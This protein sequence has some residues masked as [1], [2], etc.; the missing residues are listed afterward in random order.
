MIL[1]LLGNI[2]LTSIQVIN[3]EYDFLVCSGYCP[4]VT[5]EP[6]AS[7]FNSSSA[8]KVDIVP[9]TGHGL[10]F[11]TNA[12]ETYGTIIDFLKEHGI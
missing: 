8:F 1:N 7:N 10:N 5:D 9:K 6:S 2:L 12:P 4:G 11:H 3:G